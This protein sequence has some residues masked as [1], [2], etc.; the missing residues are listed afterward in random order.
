MPTTPRRRVS[1]S[2]AARSDAGDP[3][4]AVAEAGE[5]VNGRAAELGGRTARSARGAL[6]APAAVARSVRDDV[7]AARRPDAVL[8]WGGAAGFAAMGVL[9]FPVAAAVGVGV[10]AAG[11]VRRGRG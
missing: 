7:A 10:V 1:D 3:V 8:Y 2:S 11:V 9:E 5:Q 6:P 4:G